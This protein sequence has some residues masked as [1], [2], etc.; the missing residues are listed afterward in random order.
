MRGGSD[1]GYS[2]ERPT[3]PDWAESGEDR[4]GDPPADWNESERGQPGGNPFSQDSVERST[5]D[6]L[7]QPSPQD[8]GNGFG[9]AEDNP[10]VI[11]STSGAAGETS[12]SAETWLLLGAAVLML[13][14][15]ILF[16]IRFKRY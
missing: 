1:F 8:H 3:P 15:G 4:F 16:A 9:G 7:E 13:A 12:V 11:Q 2:S 5:G 14:V 10:D 6:S